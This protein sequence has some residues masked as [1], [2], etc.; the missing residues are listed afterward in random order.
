MSKHY[1]ICCDGCNANEFSSI[2]YKCQICPDYDL[3]STCYNTKKETQSH[4]NSHRMIEIGL[5]AVKKSDSLA[6]KHTDQMNQLEA[7]YLSRFSS[8]ISTDS[9]RK[10]TLSRSTEMLDREVRTKMISS[11][12]TLD[13][14]VTSESWSKMVSSTESLNEKSTRVKMF[15]STEKLTERS[16]ADNRRDTRPFLVP[17]TDNRAKTTVFSVEHLE[18]FSYNEL[19]EFLIQHDESLRSLAEKCKKE[20]VSGLDLMNFEDDDYKNLMITYGE[21]KKLKLL[22]EQKKSKLT[23]PSAANSA[24]EQAELNHLR[25]TLQ[26]YNQEIQEKHEVIQRLEEIA[27]KRD[28]YAQKRALIIKELQIT[29]EQQSAQH[30][31]VQKLVQQLSSTT[32][33]AK[34]DFSQLTPVVQD[35]LLNIPENATKIP[36]VPLSSSTV[37]IPI[38]QS[39]TPI[40]IELDQSIPHIP[41]TKMS[42]PNSSTGPHSS[43]VHFLT[44]YHP[45][46]NALVTKPVIHDPYD[47]NNYGTHKLIIYSEDSQHIITE[48]LLNVIPEIEICVPKQFAI[49]DSVNNV[50]SGGIITLK[51]VNEESVLFTGTTDQDGLIMLPDNLPDGSY[52]VEIHSPNNPKLQHLKFVMVIFQNRRQNVLN[53]FIGRSDLESNQIHIVLEWNAE[54]RD[55]D[56]HLYSSDGRH[57]YFQNK[58]DRDMTLDC[59]VT[60]GFGPETITFT[61]QPNLKYVYAVHRYSP[62]PKL[63]QSKAKVT[64][65]LDAEK[66]QISKVGSQ[67]KLTNSE[68]HYIPE[69]TRPNATFWIVCM[70]DGSTKQIRFFPNT[71]EEHNS[72][73]TDLIGR[74]IFLSDC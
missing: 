10:K 14:R 4:L 39:N 60:T 68:T 53:K 62:E 67:D 47:M 16:I 54:P 66:T 33:S 51:S 19:H 8:N 58:D 12:E 69:I 74:T 41:T 42:L 37:E 45:D 48:T 63:T 38:I 23:S 26:T 57:V 17:T 65:Y 18:K 6:Q 50:V 21:K 71:F 73:D 70:I 36:I 56:S 52:R 29:L 9:I 46:K 35:Q 72:F 31:L 30:S 55:L 64:F 27:I 5:P 7:A 34:N 59:D 3:C 28:Q 32:S 25:Q 20:R 15:A 24:Q 49:R 40:V 13:K 22:I 2:R 1:G 43:S 61:F 11:T 44:F